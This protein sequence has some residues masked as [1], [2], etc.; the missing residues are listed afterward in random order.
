LLNRHSIMPCRTYQPLTQLSQLVEM[1]WYIWNAPGSPP[2]YLICPNGAMDLLIHLHDR[3]V[4]LY[5]DAACERVRGP[6]LAGPKSQSLSIDPA[7]FTAVLGVRFRPGAARLFFPLPAD[8]LHNSGV[9]L[10]DLYPREAE[11]LREEI[12]S[13]PGLDGKIAALQ[14]YLIGRLPAAV[15][16]DPAVE[17]AVREFD[18]H[19]GVRPVS[20]VQ[21]EMGLS[22]TRF[23]QL[24]RESVGMTPKLFCRVRRFQRA[25]QKV[26]SG[27][28]INWADLAATCG[29]FDQAHLIR[30]FRSFSGLTPLAYAEFYADYMRGAAAAAQAAS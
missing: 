21:S 19:R 4:T 16:I 26:E 14:R 29:Y 8:E 24:F 27:Q 6:L 1:L 13:I 17:H 11:L 7:E 18:G 9:P 25:L 5:T 22:H 12:L 10:S 2:R 20:E 28:S 30:D 23:I 3:A 15:P